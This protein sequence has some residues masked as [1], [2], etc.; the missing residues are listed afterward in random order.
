[1]NDSIVPLR[2]LHAGPFSKTSRW[3]ASHMF[4]SMQYLRK[5]WICSA[6]HRADACTAPKVM[7]PVLRGKN[8]MLLPPDEPLPIMRMHVCIRQHAW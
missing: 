5:L 6:I 1:M 7:T 3:P 8:V 2:L 4:V